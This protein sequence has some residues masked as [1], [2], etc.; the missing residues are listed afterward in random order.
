M[1]ADLLL[2]TYLKRLRLPTVPANSER[3]RIVQAR[4]PVL[5]T[6][7]EFQFAAIPA[8][9]RQGILELAQSNYIPAKENVVFLGPL[10]LARPICRSPWAWPPADRGIGSA[11]L[12]P[13]A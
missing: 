11:S 13:P 2:E 9:N 8:L 1:G 5:K 3:K 12:P 10:A 7:D 6:L 4:F